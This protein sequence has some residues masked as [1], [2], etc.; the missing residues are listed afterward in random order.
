MN[1][2][3]WGS[4]ASIAG[5]VLSLIL[6]IIGLRLRGK[7]HYAAHRSFNDARIDWHNTLDACQRNLLEDDIY[8]RSMNHQMV[9][10]VDQYSH[11]R[12][13]LSLRERWLLWRLR[14][15][16]AKDPVYMD[17]RKLGLALGHFIQRFSRE[18]DFL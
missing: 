8:D 9:R 7:L 16:L 3:Y 4:L 14:G 10:V 12:R 13:L 11:L 5:L 1:L 2:E 6:V 18:R 15:L 17:R